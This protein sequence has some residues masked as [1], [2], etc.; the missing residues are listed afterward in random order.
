LKITMFKQFLILLI[1]TQIIVSCSFFEDK[2]KQVQKV[3]TIVD[4]NT[5]DAFPLFPDCKDIPSREKQQICFQV[6]MAEHI[7]AALKEHSLNAK[8]SVNDTVF[9]SIKVDVNGKISLSTIK[10][11]EKTQSLLP[12]FDSILSLSVKKLPALKPA[13]KR[14]MPVT[15]EFTLPIILTN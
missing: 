9:V 6:E 8:E 1:C 11:S 4:F 5:V 2:S 12:Q 15:T 3:D 10:I 14:N 7:Y 13:I